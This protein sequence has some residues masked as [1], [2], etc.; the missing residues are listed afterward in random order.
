VEEEA[1]KMENFPILVVKNDK[2]KNREKVR[3]YTISLACNKKGEIEM[4]CPFSRVS[5]TCFGIDNQFDVSCN[6]YGDKDTKN[7]IPSASLCIKRKCAAWRQS[8]T[9]CSEGYCGLAGPL[10]KEKKNW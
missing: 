7:M 6:R 9:K 8:K 10:A 5:V 3:L 4:W 1:M 2:E